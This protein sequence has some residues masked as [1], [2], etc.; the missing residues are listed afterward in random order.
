MGSQPQALIVDDEVEMCRSLFRLLKSAGIP[1]TSYE[2][3][4]DF[5]RD[6]TSEQRGCLVLDLRL[7]GMTG[8]ELQDEMKQRGIRLPI[9]V[10]SGHATVPDTI[11]AFHGGAF[12]VF[13]K[14]F[15]DEQLLSAVQ[16]ALAAQHSVAAGDG[17]VQARLAELS[18]RQ[19]EVMDLLV[20][21][22]P[23][24]QVA[25]QLQISPS[26]VAKHRAK[27]LE[28]AGA[29]SLVQL[30]HSVLRADAETLL[31]P[32]LSFRAQHSTKAP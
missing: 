22:V 4:E 18:D 8:L 13:E 30:A 25:N 10:I 7:G 27:V 12:R 28:K 17:K 19:R 23:V 14:P 9:I 24:K 21:G 2:S 20:Q 29:D 16:E 15:D 11:R 31:S 6:V 1:S 3:A 5:L 26:T 32:P